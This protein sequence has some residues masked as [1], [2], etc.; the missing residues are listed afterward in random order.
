MVIRHEQMQTL[1]AAVEQNFQQQ[2][3]DEMR[4]FAPWH[5][6]VLGDSGLLRCVQF[7]IQRSRKYGFTNRG[8]IRLYLQMIFLLGADFDSDALLPWAGEILSNPLIANQTDRATLLYEGLNDYL[9]HVAGPDNKFAKEALVRAR[10]E[11]SGGLGGGGEDL[12]QTIFNKVRRVYPEKCEYAGDAAVRTSIQSGILAAKR[13]SVATHRGASLF[14]GLIFALGHGFE[15]D[16]HLPWIQKTLH[17]P[18][19]TEDKLVQRL[20]SRVKTYLDYVIANV[21]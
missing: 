6:E 21:M 12:R 10:E 18:A 5:A 8:P 4:E 11:L 2:L 13:H 15:T 1:S 17:D 3:V 9:K 16:P 14:C 19:L 20:S 7:A